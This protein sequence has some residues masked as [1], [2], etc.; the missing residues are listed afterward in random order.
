[1][2]KK[3]CRRAEK[4]YILYYELSI[5]KF[6]FFYIECIAA[7]INLIRLSTPCTYV[8]QVP[9]GTHTIPKL[10]LDIDKTAY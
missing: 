8:E 4:S 2:K 7:A 10:I 1:M 5:L 9:L 6:E 3:K